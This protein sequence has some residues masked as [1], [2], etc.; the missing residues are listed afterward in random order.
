VSTLSIGYHTI[1]ASYSGDSNC[2]PSSGTVSQK[3]NKACTSTSLTFTKSGRTVTFTATVTPNTATGTVTFY[4]G[5]TKLGTVSL[6]GGTATF[7]KSNLSGH[8]IKAVYNG[9]ANFAGST[10]N[11]VRP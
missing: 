1:T 3:V 10:S 11:T 5:C 2:S 6:S 7:S 4:D 9:D 8:S